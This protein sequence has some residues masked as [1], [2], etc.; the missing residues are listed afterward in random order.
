MTREVDIIFDH[1]I[2]NWAEGNNSHTRDYY[3]S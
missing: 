2:I 3:V 1:E